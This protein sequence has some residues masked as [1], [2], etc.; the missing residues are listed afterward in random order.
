MPEQGRRPFCLH[1]SSIIQVY[2]RERRVTG[3]H[4]VCPQFEGGC[5]GGRCL[6]GLASSTEKLAVSCWA[7]KPAKGML[8]GGIQHAPPNWASCMQSRTSG[9]CQYRN[10]YFHVICIIDG[11]RRCTYSADGPVC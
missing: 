6:P 10:V 5:F 7:L 1:A 3:L 2:C 8:R 11:M 4:W 9:C